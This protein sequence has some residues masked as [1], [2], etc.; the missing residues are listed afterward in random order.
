MRLDDTNPEKEQQIFAAD[1]ILEDVR[2]LVGDGDE[3]PWFEGVRHASD[4]FDVL[5][6]MR[7]PRGEVTGLDEATPTSILSPPRT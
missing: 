5:C 3:D 7:A 2:W 4:Y 6:S 1:A